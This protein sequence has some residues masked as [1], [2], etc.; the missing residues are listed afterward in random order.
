MAAHQQGEYSRAVALLAESLRLGRDIGARDL[1]A[2]GLE[3]L[4]WVAAARGQPQRAA[5]MGGAAQALREVLGVPLPAEQ[6]AG[7]D[8][9][10]QAMRAALG[11]EG[12]AAAWTAGRALPL[13]DAIAIA[14]TPA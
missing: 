4:A 10:V 11:E 7:H 13:E 1:V 14:L 6:R 2:E 12:F 9:A 5:Q 3:S 8:Q